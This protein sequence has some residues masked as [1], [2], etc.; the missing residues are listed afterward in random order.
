M[1]GRS[2]LVI[3]SNCFT[4]S[5]VVDALLGLPGNSVVG[6]SRSPEYK[7]LFLP[8]RKRAAANF[9]FRQID[10]VSQFDELDRLLEEVKPQVVINVAALSEVALSHERPVE[11]FETNTLAVVRLADRLRRSR[12][13]ERYLHVSSAEVL[14]SCDHPLDEEAPLRPTTPYAAS[15]AAADLHLATVIAQHHFPATLIRSTNV[16]GKHQQLFKIIPRTI[17][18]LKT[19]KTIDLHGGGKAIKSFIHVRDVVSGLL[20]ALK[21][22]RNGIYHLSDPSDRTV[23]DVVEDI[24]ERLGFEFESAT[25]TVA[26]RQGQDSRYWLDCTR[27][28]REL[29]WSP[30]ISFEEGLEEVIAWIEGNWPD[31]LREPQDCHHQQPGAGQPR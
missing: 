31:I 9:R 20:L 22:D 8:Y 1:S 13:L 10:V 2:F 26:E 24:C 15:K 23:G 25:R 4:G 21:E 12:S 6:V 19:G 30:R 18:S 7:D 27:A 3:G 11:Y 5:H 28:H 29:G 14:G 16:Y 17:I